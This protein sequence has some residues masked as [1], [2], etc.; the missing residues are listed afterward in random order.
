M[1]ACDKGHTATA[2]VLIAKGLD[3]EAKDEVRQR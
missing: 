1:V 3:V 2:E